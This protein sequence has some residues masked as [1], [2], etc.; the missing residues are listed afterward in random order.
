M[1]FTP[2]H[3]GPGLAVKAVMQRKFSLLVFGWSQVAI[4]LQ[5]LIAMTTGRVELHGFSHTL[6]G[7]TLIG[8]LCGATGKHLGEWGLRVLREPR[9]LP[10]R[11]RVSFG[12]AFIGTY[13]HV[14]ID[15]VMHVDVLPFAPFSLARPLHAAISIDALHVLCVATA[16]VGGLAWWAIDRAVRR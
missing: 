9:H 3:M 5:P 15:S 10:I 6:V 1:P 11:W 4:D 2:L 16:V 12:S 8:L 7:A 14:L 13:S